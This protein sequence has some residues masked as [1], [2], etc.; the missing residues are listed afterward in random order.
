MQS[1]MLHTQSLR[2]A[3]A[4]AIVTFSVSGKTTMRMA[5]ERAPVFN[6]W[7]LS[8]NIKNSKKKLN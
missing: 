5:K 2:N 4:K 3:E 7:N 8:P 1:P 6:C